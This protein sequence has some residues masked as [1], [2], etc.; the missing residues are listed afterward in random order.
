MKSLSLA[1]VLLAGLSA[2]AAA[3]AQPV[4]NISGKRHA[5]LAAAQRLTNEAFEKISAAQ[6]ANE[7]DMEGHAAKAKNL[8]DE[9][10]RELN[11]AA[12]AANKNAK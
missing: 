7:Y 3:T 11:A 1:V 6:A 10:N 2:C 4:E 12:L 8:L 5:N 9:A